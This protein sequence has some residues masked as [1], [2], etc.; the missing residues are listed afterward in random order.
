MDMEYFMNLHRVLL[1]ISNLTL[2]L[3]ISGCSIASTSERNKL[4]DD[5]MSIAEIAH[6]TCAGKSNVKRVH[7]AGFE[8]KSKKR[9]Q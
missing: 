8:C 6:K 7:S 2:I 1:I 9:S 3:I 5:T 4:I